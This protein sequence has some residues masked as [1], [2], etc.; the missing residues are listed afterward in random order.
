MRGVRTPSSKR[1]TRY[2]LVSGAP[3]DSTPR[4]NPG[5]PKHPFSLFSSVCG[6][7][8]PRDERTHLSG[9]LSFFSIVNGEDLPSAIIVY[10][11]VVLCVFAAPCLVAISAYIAPCLRS[12]AIPE[13][14][15]LSLHS[16]SS[17]RIPHPATAVALLPVHFLRLDTCST[18]SRTVVSSS[19]R[20]S[21][22]AWR[23]SN[24]PYLPWRATEL[25]ATND[26]KIKKGIAR[27][28][29]VARA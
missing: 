6:A 9:W 24:L 8:W 29:G 3:V 15:Q 21:R 12:V 20:D 26:L 28:S 1:P 11:F 27:S 14:T 13:A 16:R 19:G 4:V 17:R 25:S 5:T 7:V 2:T 23:M 18:R 10:C 22:T